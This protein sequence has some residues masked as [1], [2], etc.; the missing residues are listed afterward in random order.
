[1]SKYLFW[2]QPFH[3][4]LLLK[5][6]VLFVVFVGLAIFFGFWIVQAGYGWPALA[7]LTGFIS[8]ALSEEA[9]RRFFKDKH[10]FKRAIWEH[11]S[12]V[13]PRVA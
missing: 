9:R 2:L 12:S 6:Y 11:L 5:Y 3:L 4:K 13:L 7:C 8:G 1:M 10:I